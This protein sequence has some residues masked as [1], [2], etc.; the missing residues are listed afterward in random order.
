MT[1]D[2]HT[3]YRAIG[4]LATTT[5]FY[6]LRLSNTQPSAFEANALTDCAA[7]AVIEVCG[8]SIIFIYEKSR[9]I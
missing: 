4:K 6:D 7:T 9:D 1:R 5:C 8:Q 3:T 2:K